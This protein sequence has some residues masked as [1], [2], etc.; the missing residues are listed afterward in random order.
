MP[1]FE[2]LL[3]LWGLLALA[4][5]T[6]SSLPHPAER[7]YAASCAGCHGP[8]GEGASG[9]SLAQAGLERAATEQALFDVIRNG[10]VGTEMPGTRHFTDEEVRQVADY[11][12]SLGRAAVRAA[13]GNAARGEELVRAK[14]G[15]QK[16]HTLRGRGGS[17]GPDLTEIG[18]RRSPAYL[19]AALLDPEAA[20]PDNFSTYRW[21]TVIPDNF[22]QLRVSTRD[23]RRITGARVNEDAF[24]IQIRDLDGRHYSFWKDELAEIRKDWGKSPMPSFRKTFSDAELDDVVAWLLSLRG[25]S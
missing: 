19:R 17:L 12:R 4:P 24:S 16:C 5:Q 8:Q 20:V 13:S 6:P 15:C 2:R 22:L 21:V 7:H 10:I 25:G 18:A 1:T 9:P 11:V 3:F 14:G 23:G